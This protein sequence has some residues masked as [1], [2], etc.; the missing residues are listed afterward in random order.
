MRKVRKV[1]ADAILVNNPQDVGYLSGFTGDDSYLLV[2]SR[3]TCLITDGRYSQQSA[4]ECPGIDIHVRGGSMATAIASAIK[5]KK[6]RRLGL[7]ERY[8]PLIGKRVLA[9]ALG[10][11]GEKRLKITTDLVG[12]LRVVKDASEIRTISRAVGKAQDAF[13]ELISTGARAFVG[14]TERQIAAKLDYLMC[15]GGAEARAFETIVGAGANTAKPHHRPTNRK[16]R[17]S[18]MVLIDWGAVVDGYH[19]D[20]T[21]VLFMDK[22]LPKTAEIYKIVCR[23]QKAG[24]DALKPGAACKTADKAAREVLTADGY[25]ERFVHGLG[26]GLGRHV[27][28]APTLGKASGER[29]RAGMVV[30]VEP[31][32]YIPSEGG[33]RIE[34]DVV[35]TRRGRRKLSSLTSELDDVILQ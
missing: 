28:E 26:H 13:R 7:Q 11:N 31:G 3:W 30:T 35:I 19:S 1:P 10:K 17:R 32:I 8:M 6:I 2:A 33:I 29:L 24:V 9:D 23:A 20:L 5:G 21:R 27:H 18:D 14:S 12:S 4:G 25:G 15:S 34:D 22:I 16:I